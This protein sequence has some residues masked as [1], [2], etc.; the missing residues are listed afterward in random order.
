MK[1]APRPASPAGGYVSHGQRLPITES[2]KGSTK[3]ILR[4]IAALIV[5]G[6]R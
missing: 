4:G 5:T 3:L 2:F 1:K 6:S